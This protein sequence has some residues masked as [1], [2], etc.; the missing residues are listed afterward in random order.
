MIEKIVIP[1][2]NSFCMRT[3]LRQI[4]SI[5]VQYLSWFDAKRTCDKFTLNS[6]V[7][8]FEVTIPEY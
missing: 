3:N 5:P 8:P 6:M 1:A 4:I 2:S 7:G